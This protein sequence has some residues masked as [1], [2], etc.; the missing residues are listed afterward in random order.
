MIKALIR[1]LLR[2]FIKLSHLARLATNLAL[3]K[4]QVKLVP[5]KSAF[6]QLIQPKRKKV[7][8]NSLITKPNLEI[9]FSKPQISMPKWLSLT[10]KV[11]VQASNKI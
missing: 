1:S 4:P 3:A 11:K 10:E 9:N 5:R 8:V 7:L 6:N 2:L